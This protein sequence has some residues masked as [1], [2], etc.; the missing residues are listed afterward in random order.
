MKKRTLAIISIVI[1]LLLVLLAWGLFGGQKTSEIYYECNVGVGNSL[2]W[3]WE[4]SAIGDAV[5]K[6]K[7]IF[8]NVSIKELN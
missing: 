5:D 3:F 4:K 1:I 8:G 6:L 7:D 2:C